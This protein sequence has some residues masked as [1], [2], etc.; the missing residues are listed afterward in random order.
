MAAK[1]TLTENGAKTLSDSG[2]PLVNLF[3]TIGSARNNP[4]VTR[5]NFKKAFEFD[6]L[7]ASAIVLCARD[8]RHNGMGERQIFRTLLKDMAGSG[9]IYTQK[10]VELIPEIGRFDDLKA[11]EG[12]VYEKMAIDIFA[13]AIRERNVLAAKWAKREDKKLQLALG[14]NEAGL[15]KL[16][17]SIR[18]EHIVEA[19]MCLKDWKSIEYGKIPSVA[20]TRYSK[21]FHKNDGIRY[22]AFIDNPDTKVNA[23]ASFPYDVYR[24]WSSRTCQPPE[25][26]KY[27]NNLK[28]LELSGSVLAIVDTSDSM[29]WFKVAG[30]LVPRDIAVS[31][32]VYCAQK[33]EGKFKNNMMT[34]NSN[35]EFFTLPTGD[36]CQAFDKVMRSNIGGSTNIQKAYEKILS[37]AQTVN[38]TDKDM[39]KFILIISDMQFN[40]CTDRPSDTVYDNMRKKYKAAGFT[41]PKVIFWNMDARHDQYPTAS[42]QKETALI[43]GFSPNILKAVLKGQDVVITPE[44]IMNEAIAPF[45]EMLK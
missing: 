8:I 15:R 29:T 33:I 11:V 38:A 6:A 16:L 2:N 27:W 1:Y 40:G 12:T 23:S 30:S 7:R 34:F 24:M 18:K 28:E 45:I 13:K 20:G 22:R 5:A 36:V 19:K 32:G 3:F 39:P 26:N 41:M 10:I 14:L 42:F 21:A 35:P 9:K 17:A 37:M 44:G 31:L 4:E 25:I 43:S